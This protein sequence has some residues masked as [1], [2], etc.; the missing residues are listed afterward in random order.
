MTTGS[1]STV[2]SSATKRRRLCRRESRSGRQLDHP[3]ERVRVLTG[4]AAVEAAQALARSGGQQPG[5]LSRPGR[6]GTGGRRRAAPAPG[7]RQVAGPRR[8][9]RGRRRRVRRSRPAPAR[10]AA[11][12]PRRGRPRPS[13]RNFAAVDVGGVRQERG[14]IR[15]SPGVAARRSAA[16]VRPG[17]PDRSRPDAAERPRWPAPSGRPADEF[18]DR[19]G[20]PGLGQLF[21]VAA[22][23]EVQA[24]G[25]F[26]G[27][28]GTLDRVDAQVGLEIEVRARSSPPDTRSAPRSPR[29]R[30]PA[31]T[32]CSPRRRPP[33]PRRGA[34]HRSARR[35]PRRSGPWRTP[36]RPRR[37]APA[38]S[39]ARRRSRRA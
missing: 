27:D 22:G 38:G 15:P 4:E 24:R 6:P 37:P 31:P 29:A 2:D 36:P 34:R 30:S 16:R 3:G 1:R 9:R 32:P 19:R 8:T 35:S 14:R 21:D 33:A 39:P 20:G 25:Q 12:R 17:P 10:R 18:G 28:L 23:G 26:P 5:G 7:V 13:T 11:R